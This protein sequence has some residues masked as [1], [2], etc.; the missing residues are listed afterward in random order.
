VK[1][2]M[3]RPPQTWKAVERAVARLLAGRR[4]HFERQDVECARFSVE[5]KHGGQIPSALLKWWEQAQRNTQDGKQPL[6]VMHPTGAGYADSL[7][8][9]RL[10]DLLRLLSEGKQ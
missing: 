7:V 9:M 4:C 3:P 2:P 6:L 5:V 10:A 8:A 1:R